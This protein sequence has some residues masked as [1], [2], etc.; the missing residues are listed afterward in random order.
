[1]MVDQNEKWPITKALAYHE[2]NLE[3]DLHGY[4][5]WYY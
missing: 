3:S 2:E 4:L 5:P 1:M